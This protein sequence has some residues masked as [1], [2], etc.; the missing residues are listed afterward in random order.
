MGNDFTVEART[1]VYDTD[2]GIYV[3]FDISAAE[4]VAVSVV[5]LYSRISGGDV[6]VTPEGVSASFPGTVP[7]GRYGVEI[8]FRDSEGKGRVFERNLFEVVGSSGEA[9][10][11]SSSKG[12]TGDGHNIS[13]DVRTRTVRIGKTT[14]LTNYTL[15]ENKPSINGHVLEGDKT[16]DEL[17]FYSKDRINEL[18]ASKREVYKL[19]VEEANALLSES[20]Y[21]MESMPEIL[22]PLLTKLKEKI[23]MTLE[24]PVDF[25]GISGSEPGFLFT[26]LDAYCQIVDIKNDDGEAKGALF[27]ITGNSPGVVS[28]GY[29]LTQV[30]SPQTMFQG[31]IQKYPTIVDWD[32]NDEKQSGYIANKPDVQR[33]LVQ[34]DKTNKSINVRPDVIYQAVLKRTVPI[35]VGI[36]PAEDSAWRH[37]WPVIASRVAHVSDTY[38]IYL[39]WI[40]TSDDYV[41]LNSLGMIGKVASDTKYSY[42][43]SKAVNWDRLTSL[44][45]LIKNGNGTK[46][47]NDKGEY[48]DPVAGVKSSVEALAPYDCTWAFTLALNTEVSQD[49]FLELGKAIDDGRPLICKRTF[50]EEDWNH[51][52]VLGEYYYDDEDDRS[53]NLFGLKGWSRTV[54]K[55]FL[56]QEVT[57]QESGDNFDY[58]KT[59]DTT[60]SIQDRLVSGANIKTVNGQSLLGAG[61]IV[62]DKAVISALPDVF[63]GTSA[64][65]FANLKELYDTGTLKLNNIY[66]GNTEL[67]DIVAG[68]AV[69]EM[70]VEVLPGD[71]GQVVFSAVATTSTYD[72]SLKPFRW[73]TQSLNGGFTKWVG[74]ATQDSVPTKV[75]ELANDA[76]YVKADTLETITDASEISVT[77]ESGKIRQGNNIATLTIG[78]S[79]SDDSQAAE[80]RIIF[81]TGPSV[82]GITVTGV[83]WANGDTPSFKANKV[84]EISVSYVPMLGRFLATYAEY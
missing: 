53:I 13:V 39:N 1:S 46:F 24:A 26:L 4:D 61:D 49:K 73:E 31:T 41:F 48:A 3:P 34:I 5:G 84:Y 67:T 80:E 75:S 21:P 35:F 68:L 32:I 11:E 18:L 70:R 20:N 7:V 27:L 29:Q 58:E 30:E 82:E 81:S 60:H 76:G 9:T 28:V 25:L 2:K 59:K 56:V 77:C 19:S 40:S 6:K 43:T 51:Y 14:G 52:Y 63:G 47:L 42:L 74:R 38:S 83:S 69:Q 36:P 16:A 57:L 50:G 71:G 10:L 72:D 8:L 64:E 54:Y 66:Y 23:W 33:V 44:P 22:K 45:S 15:L 65:F 79:A 37:S 78:C 17:G 55:D 12:E 62:T